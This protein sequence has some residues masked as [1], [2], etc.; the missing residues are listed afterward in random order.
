MGGSRRLRQGILLTLR[1]AGGVGF[2]VVAELKVDVEGA[3]D[4]GVEHT[5]PLGGGLFELG[6]VEEVAGLDDDLEGVGEVVGEAADFQGEL[7]GDL[8]GGSGWGRGGEFLGGLGLGFGCAF[9]HSFVR[10]LQGRIGV[11][12]RTDWTIPGAV[13]IRQAGL[14]RWVWV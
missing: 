6:Q 13:W 5:E 12:G 7:F 8:L 2:D 4:A 14:L 1:L 10:C 11:Q 9:A 3:G